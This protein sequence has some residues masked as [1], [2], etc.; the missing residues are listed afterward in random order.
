MFIDGPTE[1]DPISGAKLFDIDAVNV[2][3]RNPKMIGL[4]DHRL[5]TIRFLRQLL[6]ATHSVIFHPV[7]DLGYI[8]PAEF[9]G[10]QVA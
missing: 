4:I 9:G 10:G 2:V 1:I 7:H 5:N 3:R 6:H 8:I